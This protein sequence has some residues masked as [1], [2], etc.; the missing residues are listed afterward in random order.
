M[1]SFVS[2]FGRDFGCHER[3]VVETLVSGTVFLR[4]LIIS[5]FIV[6]VIEF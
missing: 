2:V 3:E 4:V 6:N 5:A 1:F